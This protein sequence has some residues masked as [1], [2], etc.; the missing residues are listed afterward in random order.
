MMAEFRSKH[1]RKD[2]SNYSQFF[3]LQRWLI[4]Q[5]KRL[6]DMFL[7]M[8]ELSRTVVWIAMHGTVYLELSVSGESYF[9][10]FQSHIQRRL[11]FVSYR[12]G[13]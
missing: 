3:G 8:G 11:T 9:Q 10:N 13:L 6:T 2:A 5:G 4:E 7:C 1:V 12:Q